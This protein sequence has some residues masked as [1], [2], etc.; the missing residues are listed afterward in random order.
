MR[1]VTASR[2]ASP[3][4]V[5]VFEPDA[6]GHPREWLEHLVAFA[7]G[8]PDRPAVTFLVA[9]GMCGHLAA[10]LPAAACD[11]IRILPLGPLERW[12]CTRRFLTL[13]AFARWWT[14]RRCLQRTGAQAGH[15]LSFDHLCLPLA[16]GLGTAGRP[17]SGILFRPSVHYAALGAYRPS[18]PERLRDLRKAVLYRLMLRNGSVRAVLSLD[19]YFPSYARD[20]YR[21]GRKV[22]AVPDPAFPASGAAA[23][24]AGQA[25]PAD[26]IRFVL[27]GY[28]TERKGLLVLLDALARVDR[29]LAPRIAVTIAGR[30]EPALRA[31]VDA[32]V[33]H[34]GAARPGLHLQIDDRWLPAG[35]LDALVT[36]SDV[37]LAPY[38]RFVGSSGVLLWAARAGLPLLTQ[39]FGL[40]GRLVRDH[41]LGLAVDTMDPV[42]VAAGIERMAVE[43]PKRFVDA[44][45]ARRFADAC[46]PQAFASTVIG[47]LQCD[48]RGAMP[49]P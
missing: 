5:V 24:E 11:R 17:V 35:E 43:G 13:A 8:A 9:A 32:R 44:A 48:G 25:A 20:R 1:S 7:V 4:H 28:L 16:L 27:F 42:A 29:E 36:R 41:R 39:D 2:T 15:F 31:S 47:S 46:T 23:A 19:P 12:L 30:V 3:H 38:Q 18:P 45:A 21:L 37:V 14:M 10:G 49:P 33:R 22:V 40:L 26:R 6:E 34:V